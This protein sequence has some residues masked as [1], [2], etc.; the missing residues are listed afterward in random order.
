MDPRHS[1]FPPA[2]EPSGLASRAATAALSRALAAPVRLAVFRPE[3]PAFLLGTDATPAPSPARLCLPVAMP[4]LG[5]AGA[6]RDAGE[7]DAGERDDGERDDGERD[8][9]GDDGGERDGE[10][11]RTVDGKLVARVIRD[12]RDP[13][14]VLRGPAAVRELVAD[15]I[16]A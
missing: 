9:G 6:G 14:A 15:G 13:H 10:P 3:G 16:I 8:G 7:R 4:R 11:C 5:E 2:A 1:L 12:R